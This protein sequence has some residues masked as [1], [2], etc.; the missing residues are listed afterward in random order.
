M[1]DMVFALQG[2]AY[3][4][5]SRD[6][7]LWSQGERTKVGTNGSNFSG[8]TDDNPGFAFV[9]EREGPLHQGRVSYSILAEREGYLVVKDQ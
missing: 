7:H 2:N 9:E 8:L 1:P 3:D 6:N 5:L 4:K